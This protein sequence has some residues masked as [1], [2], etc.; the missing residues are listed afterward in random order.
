M[1]LRGNDISR[2]VT[3][4]KTTP[5]HE[6][7]TD[8]P[9][10]CLT[11]CLNNQDTAFSNFFRKSSR[12]PKFKKKYSASRLRFQNPGPIWEKGKLQIPKLGSVKLSEPL[13]TNAP[14]SMITIIKEAA[15]S[16]FVSF[17]SEVEVDLLPVSNRM[18]GVDLGL[19]TFATLSSSEKIENPKHYRARLRYIKRCQTALSRKV[20]GSNRYEKQRLRVASA[21]ATIR[22]K[23]HNHIHQ[24]TTRLVKEFDVICIEDLNL[25]AMIRYRHLAASIYDASF[26]EF[27]RQLTYKCNWY[28]R[29]LLIAHRSFPSSKLCSRCGHKVHKMPLVVRLWTCPACGHEHDRDINAAQNLLAD[30]IRQLSGGERCDY[31][32]EPGGPCLDNG[33]AQLPGNETRSGQ[34]ANA[35]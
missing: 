2:W 29:T 23:R 30:G 12:Y 21:H 7:L 32:A 15:G 14:P 27:R 1:R 19:T 16:Y 33:Q 28:G 26:R 17:F 20:P 10:T 34:V 4:W 22:N 25:Q 9:R 31:R 11:Q 35:S 5:G 13:P 18:V 8:I 3:Q 6:W 24:V